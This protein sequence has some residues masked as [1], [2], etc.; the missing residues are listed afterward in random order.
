MTEDR[1]RVLVA[2]DEPALREVVVESLQASGREVVA[3]GDGRE[4]LRLLL[5]ER[6]DLVILD[7][8]LPGVSGRHVLAAARSA[9]IAVPAILWSGSLN[10]EDG[11]RVALGVATFLRKPVALEI[12]EEAIRSALR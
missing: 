11:E 5:D 3:V 1:A 2:E 4:A 10:L 12:L 8:E 9:G 6:Y 7:E